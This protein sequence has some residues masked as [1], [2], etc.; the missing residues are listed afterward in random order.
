MSDDP[1]ATFL[2]A[3]TADRLQLALD[4]RH[5]EALKSY[6]GE[7]AYEAL[8]QTARQAQPVLD[9]GVLGIEA[10]TNLVLV[11]GVM[12]SL[13]QSRTLGGVWWVDVRT[14]GHL[15]DLRLAPNGR[16]DANPAFQVAPFA[17][18]VGY[19][20]FLAAVLAREDF[21]HTVFAY[22]W[23]KPLT[24]SAAALRDLVSALYDSNGH[25]PVH[26]VAHS[27][28]GLM[29]RAALMAHGPEM[30]P[31]LGRIVFLGTPHYG[32][33]AIAGYLK[34]HLWGFDMM[35]VLG[36]YIN[37]ETFRSLWGALSMIPAPR[38]IYPG[39]RPDDPAPWRPD[40]PDD[41]YVHPC[42]NFDMYDAASW[43]LDLSADQTAQLQAVL[44]GAAEFDRQL[45]QAHQ[46]LDQHLRDRMAVIAGVGYQTLFRLAYKRGFLGL[47][48]HMD[49]VTSRVPG[50]PHREGDGRVP[51]AS[52][53]LENVGVTRYVR[54]V[55]GSLPMMP[56]VYEDVFR[57]LKGQPMQ[58]PTTVEEALSQQPGT[59]EAPAVLGM[60]TT[61]GEL[62]LS[63]D[64]GYWND[65]EP[66]P[67][68]MEEIQGKLTAD[69]LPEFN[70]IR[71][72]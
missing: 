43:K 19:E 11:P 15:N 28:G 17:V 49:K 27:M 3:S 40:N 37:R 12:G 7:R 52:A 56:Q 45:Y 72:M 54:G 10:P 68:R 48:E 57:W 60:P 31:K 51:L 50:D 6:L 35:A 13:L 64:P 22:D 2:S 39:T 66:D 63:D 24:L 69:Q 32:S 65:A 21:G 16:E 70:L 4:E 5:A 62:A 1:I 71:L 55:H 34:N 18:D 30:W 47:W 67:A 44:D 59:G 38:A 42:A 9:S 36:A 29:V 25:T 33:P 20:P 46:E 41:P 61:R 14:R 26:L 8:V 53:M 23:R 58:L